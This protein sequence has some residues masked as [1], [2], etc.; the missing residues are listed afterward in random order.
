[1]SIKVDKKRCVG[2]GRCAQVCP[3]NLL[4]RGED[5]KVD[6][7]YPKDCWGCAACLKE[8]QVGAINY[9]L[10]ADIGGKGTYLYTKQEPEYLHWFFVTP[11][12][13]QRQ[14]T[15]NRREANKY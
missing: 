1:M 4:S 10:G 2:C 3:G 13:E 7:R 11:Q 5:Q 14:I 6:I 12:G 15:I 9:H 8:C